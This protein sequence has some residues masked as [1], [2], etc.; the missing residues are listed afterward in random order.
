MREQ[1]TKARDLLVRC[2]CKDFMARDAKGNA[3]AYDSTKAVQWCV[4]GALCRAEV[5]TQSSCS[6]SDIAERMMSHLP[7]AWRRRYSAPSY[8]MHALVDY[9]NDPATT[10]ADMVGLLDKTIAALP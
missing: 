4:L 6:H 7:E 3:A 8:D 9:N 5:V 10:Q 1:L 2:F